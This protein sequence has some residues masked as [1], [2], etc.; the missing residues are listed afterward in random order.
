MRYKE[1]KEQSAEILRQVIAL[2]G[3][4]GAA[5]NPLSFAVWYEFAAGINARLSQAIAQAIQSE[6][7]LGDATI[8]RLYQDHVAQVDHVAMQHI[9]DELQR[10]MASI[11]QSAARTGDQAGLFGAQ[12]DGLTEALKSNDPSAIAPFVVNALAGT[13]EM[14]SSAQELQEQV[15][16]SRQ[17]IARLQADLVRTRDEA[18]LDPLT[19]ILNRKGFDQK[20]SDMLAQSPGPQESHCLIMLDIDHFK[21]V[22]DTHG[23]VMGDR[24]IQ[25]LGD[26]LRSCVP[27]KAHSVA[28]YGGEEFAVLLPNCSLD[29]GIKLADTV[30][31]RTKA[32]KIR[33]RRTQEVVLTVSISGGV[34]AMQADDDAQGLIARA[35]G[36]LYKSKQTGRDRVSVA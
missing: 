36:A 18:L 2:M 1:S 35:D 16:S 24:V 33:D 21:K 27:D 4:H 7:K 15:L 10:M 25:A 17:E 11:N 13:A 32:M 19:K 3:Q 26:V 8:S 28:R 23:H 14:K 29:Y 20:M 22:N 5:F 9:T 30:R 6:P 34:A 12:L 31:L